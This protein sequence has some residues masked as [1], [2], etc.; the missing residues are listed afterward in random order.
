MAKKLLVPLMVIVFSAIPFITSAG[1]SGSA[2]PNPLIFTS[3]S[4]GSTVY[5]VSSA[6]AEGIMK[7]RGISVKVIPASTDAGRLVPLQQG[8][9]HG[10]ILS[11][12]SHY[13]M[14]RGVGKTFGEWGPQKLRGLMHP[15]DIPYGIAARGD[16]GLK[17]WD[18]LKGKTCYVIAGIGASERGIK[19]LLAFGDLTFDDVKVKKISGGYGAGYKSILE[20]KVDFGI[21]VTGNP[22]ALEMEATCGVTW[23]EM[24]PDDKEGWARTKKLAPYMVPVT[25]KKN[26]ATPEHPLRISGIPMGFY[27]YNSMS[28]DIVYALTKALH[29]SYPMYKDIHHFAAEATLDNTIKKNWSLSPYHPGA[30]KYFRELG[31][32]TTRHEKRQQQMLSDEEQR[33]K[34]WNEKRLKK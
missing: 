13:D 26:G 16:S 27:V 20:K 30:I 34:T 25:I 15:Y 19:S 10:I 9:A 11:G 14:I 2:L 12:L 7:L 3:Y 6:F 28:D 31:V 33:I 18:D 29:K 32:W 17:T 24:P 23:W 1:A 8:T 22:S 21:M 5:T 4:V